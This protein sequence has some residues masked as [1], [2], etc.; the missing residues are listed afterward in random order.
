MPNVLVIDDELSMREFLKI[1]LEKEG[2]AV[3]TAADASSACA[4]LG[5]ENF[6]LIISDIKMPGM[7]GLSFLEHVRDQ[8][9]TLPV[10]MI[11]AYAS[12][13]ML[14]RL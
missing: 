14:S 7:S 10:I 13:K 4:I 9:L 2:H 12:R 5:Q 1:L 6:D 8:G 3:T 11:T